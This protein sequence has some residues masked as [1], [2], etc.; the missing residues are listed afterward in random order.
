[1]YASSDRQGLALFVA[2]RAWLAHLFAAGT[3]ATELG[4]SLCLVFSSLRWY[5][6][7]AVISMHIGIRPP[8]GL[9]YIT[10]GICVLVVF[11]NW[12]VVVKG[13]RRT[14]SAALQSPLRRA[15]G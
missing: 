5:F 4:F 12:P 13:L 6:I 11:V 1:L 15:P 14:G 8:M 2:D 9:H 10:R 3:T 7:P